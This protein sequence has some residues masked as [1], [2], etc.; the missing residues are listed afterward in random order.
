D[1]IG[2]CRDPYGLNGFKTDMG[3]PDDAQDI[4]FFASISPY[5]QVKDGVE[6]PAVYISAGDADPRCP[7]LHARKFAAR[8]QAAQVGSAP[9]LVRVWEKAG[10][11]WATA[12]DVQLEQSTHWLAF[13]MRQLGMRPS[14]GPTSGTSPS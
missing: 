8:L 5:Y 14:E 11:G 12:Q 2:W 3:N 1:I 13:V 6:Y 7:P 9:I 10:H 4:A